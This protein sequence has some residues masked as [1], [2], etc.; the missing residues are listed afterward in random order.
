MN[1]TTK[2]VAEIAILAAEHPDAGEI[3][4]TEILPGEQ[5]ECPLTEQIGSADEPAFCGHIEPV[6]FTPTLPAIRRVAHD[7]ADVPPQPVPSRYVLDFSRI[8]ACKREVGKLAAA[9][10]LT[11]T[12]LYP[13][14]TSLFYLAGHTRKRLPN[15]VG[16]S[17]QDLYAGY[18]L[19]TPPLAII[20]NIDDATFRSHLEVWA[21]ANSM[22]HGFKNGQLDHVFDI[23]MR[24]TPLTFEQTQLFIEGM[25]SAR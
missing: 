25:G 10:Q 4:I 20:K 8:A 7:L 6:P 14:G 22:M 5:Y 1:V 17:A 15:N 2:A 19:Y 18:R 23:E 21:S 9:G 13:L 12:S 3:A 16:L 11:H 24:K